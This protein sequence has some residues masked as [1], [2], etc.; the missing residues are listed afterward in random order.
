MQHHYFKLYKPAGYL[1]QFVNNGPKKKSKKLLGEL[2]TFPNGTMAVG[3]L[4][5]NTEGLLFLTTDGAFNY[6]ITKGTIEKEYFA[7]V[8]GLI[9]DTAI[10]EL[11]QGVDISVN[12]KPYTTLPAKVKT[13]EAPT[14][15]PP[16]FKIRDAR[17]GPTSW[18]SITITEGKF[19]QVRK[20]TAKVGF[21]TLR[22]V[23]YRIG[24]V[25]INDLEL[26]AVKPLDPLIIDD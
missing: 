15:A 5:E 17:H 23:R 10:K 4:D 18:V 11:T 13:I 26:A 8:D 22:L 9:T 24:A 1:S 19:R 14:L 7:Q 20:M 21:P 3:R 6:K 16:P 2:H 12:S 25:T